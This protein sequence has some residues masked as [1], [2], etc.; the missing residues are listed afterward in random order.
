MTTTA[1]EPAKSD[2]LGPR[3]VGGIIDV[4]L[5]VV[6]FVVISMLFGQS[7]SSETSD[8]FSFSV[9]LNGGPFFLYL[10][11]FF[12]YHFVLEAYAGGATIGKK[13]MGLKVMKG[14]GPADPGSVAV[15]TLLRVVDVLPVF[16]LLGFIVM[17]SRTDRKRIGDIVAGTSVVRV[18]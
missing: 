17:V 18:A 12:A 14:D 6:L 8:G 7:E 4:V 3:I 2:V 5:M 15:R 16:Y 10:A 11:L 9:N 1:G 13:V